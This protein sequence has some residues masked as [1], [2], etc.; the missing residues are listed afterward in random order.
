MLI[1][2][3]EALGNIFVLIPRFAQMRILGRKLMGDFI[4]KTEIPFEMNNLTVVAVEA[5]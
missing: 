4:C 2:Y 3:E 1:V 5:A